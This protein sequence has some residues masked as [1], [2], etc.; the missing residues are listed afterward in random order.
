MSISSI[1]AS[2]K[3]SPQRTPSSAGIAGRGVR[4][5]F[6]GRSP[7][8][9]TAADLA[10]VIRRWTR[11]A[12]QSAIRTPLLRPWSMKRVSVFNRE[13]TSRLQPYGSD[14]SNIPGQFGIQ[15]IPQLPGNGGL[16]YFNING[17]SQL[18]SAEWLI[19]DR[20]S[21]TI[22]FTENLNKVYHSH[23]F[24]GGF[25]AQSIYFPWT[26][27]PFSRGEFDFNGQY[28]SIVNQTDSSTGRAQFLLTP[29]T[30]PGLGGIPLGGANQVQASNF[31]GVAAQRS[32]YGAY[33][34]DD[35]K[36]T[37]K[38]PLNLGLRWD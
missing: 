10:T 13:H 33:F 24:K 12:L 29:T 3:I 32:Y 5:S 28:T 2:T 23:T 21:N 30:A 22:Q 27:P 6:P 11:K 25:E 34:Q 7:V 26:A 1:S 37:S 14:T 38:L 20:Y 16:P 19:S 15:G 4:A 9:P 8:T 36:V 31:G 17:L 18:G 35:W